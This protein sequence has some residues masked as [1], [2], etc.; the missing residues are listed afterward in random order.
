ML[1]WTLGNLSRPVTGAICTNLCHHKLLHTRTVQHPTNRP[2]RL[3]Y[4]L[5]RHVTSA[6]L[7]KNTDI[8]RRCKTAVTTARA[9]FS[10][11]FA[12]CMKFLSG[13]RHRL[14]FTTW[15]STCKIPFV[16]GT[17][18]SIYMRNWEGR[19]PTSSSNATNLN[20]VQIDRFG[21]VC[22][23]GYTD[24]HVSH[25]QLVITKSNIFTKAKDLKDTPK[26]RCDT[27][28]FRHLRG[29]VGESRVN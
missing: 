1:P 15:S 7:P 11:L 17:S 2:V 25:P 12:N 24:K 6:P 21:L 29:A 14:G 13:K 5:L 3:L 20:N 8:A 22:K 18:W 23:H 10:S 19:K 27:I 9:N 4:V 28:P 16:H 26:R